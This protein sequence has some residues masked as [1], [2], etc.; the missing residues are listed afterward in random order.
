MEIHLQTPERVRPGHPCNSRKHNTLFGT[1]RYM[2][3][4][5]V[6]PTPTEKY[7][8]DEVEVSFH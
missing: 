8:M 1:L 4:V 5:S 6:F 7:K 2:M 3:S